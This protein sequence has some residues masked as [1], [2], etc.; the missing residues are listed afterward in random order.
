MPVC[1][2]HRLLREANADDLAR[3]AQEG[4]AGTASYAATGKAFGSRRRKGQG[5]QTKEPQVWK[6]ACSGPDGPEV[7]RLSG[8]GAP[9][10]DEA[11]DPADQGEASPGAS[12]VGALVQH[13]RWADLDSEVQKHRAIE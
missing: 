5:S 3:W 12:S 11:A 10:G 9:G 2:V 8:G 4:E 6:R 13:C 7:V 1:I